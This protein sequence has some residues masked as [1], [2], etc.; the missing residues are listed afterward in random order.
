MEKK[1]RQNIIV[2]NNPAVW[3][4][5]PRSIRVPGSPLD[6]MREVRDR[7]HRGWRLTGHPLMGS[8]RLLRNP[9]RS[10]VLDSPET[11]MNSAALLQV[12]DAYWRLS[13]VAFDTA[14][15]AS[16]SD[17]QFVDRELL[18]AMIKV[19]GES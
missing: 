5:F 15:A 10:V 2:S 17:Y 13:R 16:L 3:K 8:I 14:Q 11:E 12:E 9:Y 4:H 1:R 7:V 19:K 6:V 18:K